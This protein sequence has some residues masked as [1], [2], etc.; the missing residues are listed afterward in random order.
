M[1]FNDEDKAIIKHYHEKGYTPYRIWKENPDKKWDKSSVK[2]LI[3]RYLVHGTMER[4]K[5]SGRPVTVTT[6]KNQAAVEEMICSQ[7]ESPGT[8]VTP[9]NIAKVLKISDRS[10]RRMVKSKGIRQFK[11]MKTPHMNEGTRTRRIE[12]AASLL[13]KFRRNPRMIERAVFQD[14]SDFPLQVWLNNQNDRV[15]YKNR[16]FNIKLTKTTENR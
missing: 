11:R 15:Y 3:K 1:V 8:H 13:E 14:E 4:Q 12:R 7:E 2:R 6:P 9:N 5:G 16:N 10:V